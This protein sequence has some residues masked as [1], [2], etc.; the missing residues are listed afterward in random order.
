[1]FD[2][3][4]KTNMYTG[5]IQ[6]LMLD[7]YG[8]Q[9][10]PNAKASDKEPDCRVVIDRRATTSRSAG[11]ILRQPLSFTRPTAAASIPSNISRATPGSCRRTPMRAS[12]RAFSEA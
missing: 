11:P 9:F 4:S 6:T 10:H 2:L 1:M 7:F 5:Y 3:D 8:V 12:H